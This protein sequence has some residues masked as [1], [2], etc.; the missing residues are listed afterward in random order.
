MFSHQNVVNYDNNFEWNSS[1]GD[2]TSGV[3]SKWRSQ[4]VIGITQH[5]VRNSH[6]RLPPGVLFGIVVLM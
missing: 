3:G 4:T 6:M 2:V 1:L 5:A